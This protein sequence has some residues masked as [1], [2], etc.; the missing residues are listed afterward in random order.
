MLVLIFLFKLRIILSVIDKNAL[1]DNS[2]SR[3]NSDIDLLAT[4]YLANLR[5]LG[6]NPPSLLSSSLLSGSKSHNTES[7]KKIG[8]TILSSLSLQILRPQELTSGIR[9]LSFRLVNAKLLRGNV[10]NWFPRWCQMVSM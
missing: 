5:F 9:K 10:K 6:H 1:L 7:E 3:P 2:I 8:L 4:S